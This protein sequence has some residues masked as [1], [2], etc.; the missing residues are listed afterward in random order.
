V[1][2][3]AT[4]QLI[5]AKNYTNITWATGV[6]LNTG[7]PIETPRARYEKTAV[8]QVTGPLG[9]H[10]WQPMAFNPKT[11]LVYIPTNVTPFAYTDDKGFAFRPGAWNVGVDFLANAMPTDAATLKALTAMVKGA[12]VAWDPVQQKAVWTVNHPYFWNAGVLTTGGGLVLQGT[13]DGELAAYE[14]TSG[15]KLWSYKT[16]NGVIAAPMTYELKGEQY[17]AVMVG[18]GGGGQI[19]APGSMPQRPRLPGRL[20]VFKIGGTA[21]APEFVVPQQPPIDLTSVSSTG[22]VEHG[23]EVYN[24]TC[25]V[26]HGPN[27]TGS[28]LPDLKRSPMLLTADNW[29]GVVIDGVSAPRGMASFARFLTPKDAEDIRAF[30]IDEAKKAAAGGQ[31][32]PVP[33]G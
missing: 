23:F 32:A 8:V 29:K 19:S 9:A 6:D 12:L 30:V 27:A 28:W 22:S 21:T 17:I 5:S 7:R 26:C 2:D 4:G 20:M 1:I 11:G 10:N 33:I 24:R 13:A 3:R 18:V 25:Q 15:K 31:A 14:A 16:G